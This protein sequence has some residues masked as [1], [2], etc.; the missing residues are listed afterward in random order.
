MSLLTHFQPLNHPKIPKVIFCLLTSPE[1]H[2][3]DVEKAMFSKG[4]QSLG[5]R[6][7]PIDQP[8]MR[9]V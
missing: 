6:L 2:F 4:R 1:F 9:L 3:G 8:K 5:T 7:L